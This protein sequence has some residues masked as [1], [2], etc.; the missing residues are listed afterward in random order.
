MHVTPRRELIEA[1]TAF[2]DKKK[3]VQVWRSEMTP[4]LDE[5][6]R[7]VKISTCPRKRTSKKQS[8]SNRFKIN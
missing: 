4:L 2:W 8:P 7:Y 6:R 5:I 1:A 3:Y